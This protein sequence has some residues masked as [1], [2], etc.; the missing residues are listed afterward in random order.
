MYSHDV[1]VAKSY[2]KSEKMNTFGKV[3]PALNCYILRNIPS[4]F[5]KL[6]RYVPN[7][8]NIKMISFFSNSKKLRGVPRG[9]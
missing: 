3:E 6:G 4:I 9:R 2:L 7:I 8:V 5:T 1:E